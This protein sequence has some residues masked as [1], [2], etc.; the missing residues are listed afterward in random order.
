[1]AKAHLNPVIASHLVE[2][3]AEENPDTRVYV[4]ER[5][6]HGEDIITYKDLH[7]KA[8]RIARLLLDKGIKTGDTFAVFMRNYP[9]F[10]YVAH[11]RHDHRRDHGAH[12]P[13]LARRPAQVPADQQRRQGGHRVGRVP[14]TARGGREGRARAEVHHRGVSARPEHARVIEV[15][16]AE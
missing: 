12:R 16:R 1:M 4:F 10:V 6:E 8:N 5:G 13:A 15:P 9:E 14:G 3:K 7:E 11:R 2:I